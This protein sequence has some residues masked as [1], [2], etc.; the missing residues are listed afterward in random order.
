MKKMRLA[1]DLSSILKTCINVGVDVEGEDVVTPEGKTV[2]VNSA[3]YGYENSVNSILSALKEFD[4]TPIDLVLM[5]E[6]IS[7]KYPRLAIFGEYKL[8]REDVPQKHEQFNLMKA[9]VL[10]LFKSLGAIVIRQNYAEADDTAAYLAKNTRTDLIIMTNDNDLAVLNGTNSYGALVGVR[11]NGFVGV[12]KY[13]DFPYEY[14]TVYKA[15]VGDQSDNISGI[16]GFGAKAFEQFLARFGVAGLQILQRCGEKQTLDELYED[17]LQDKFIA[18]IFAGAEEFLRSYK[19]A[20]L[21]PEW[22]DTMNSPLVF[23][24]GL[25]L[26]GVADERVKQWAPARR[27]VT[28]ATWDKFFAWFKSTA[29]CRDWLA[30]DIETSTP[31]ESDEWVEA[32]GSEDKVDTMGS[33]LTGMSLTFG[34]N[35]QYTVYLPVDHADTDNLTTEQIKVLLEWV[36]EQGLRVKIH[37][38]MFEGPVLFNLFGAAWKDNGFHGFLPNWYD[39]KFAASY[40]NENEPL[41]LKKLA[42]MYFGYD[43]VD[44]H[45]TVTTRVTS[46]NKDVESFTETPDGRYVGCIKRVREGVNT[47]PDEDGTPPILV[48]SDFVYDHGWQ[49]KMRQHTAQHVF[50]YACDDTVVTASFANFAE[51]F[52]DLEGTNEVLDL[53]ETKASYLHAQSFVNG[54]RLDVAKLNELREADKTTAIA[55][56]QALGAYLTTLGWEGTVCPVYTPQIT[57]A[58]VKEAFLIATGKVLD[59][60]VR[61]PAKLVE[62]SAGYS[63]LFSGLLQECY[64]GKPEG[65]NELV[66]NNFKGKPMFN[67]GSPKQMQDLL[68]NTMGSPIVMRNKP[69]DVMKAKGIREGTPSTDALAIAYAMRDAKSDEVKEALRQVQLLKMT[70]IREGLYYKPYPSFVHWRTGKIHPSHNQ[71]ATNTR[72]ASSSSPNVQQMPKHQKV[73]GQPSRFREVM[74]P[75]KSKAVIVSMDFMAQELR[76]IADYS[77]DPNMLSCFVGDSLKDMHALTG[78]G[79]A[80][81]KGYEWSYDTFVEYIND[82]ES[83]YHKLAKQFRAKGKTTNFATEYGA[84]APKLSATMMIPESEAQAYID[85]R[86]DAFSGAKDW[87]LSVVA[88][89]VREGYVTTKMGAVR[90]L[91][92]AVMSPNRATSSKAE[93]QGVNTKIQGSCAEMTKLAEGRMWDAALEQRFDAQIIGPIH[94]EVVASCAIEDLY[95]FIPAMHAC[96]VEAYADMKV[97]IKSSISFGRSFGEQIEIG[98]E[99]TEEAINKGLKELYEFSNSNSSVN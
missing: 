82:T 50:D 45:T 19:L 99:P 5:E 53:V 23:E 40:V 17:S 31:I 32:Q 18:K 47:A 71:C 88:E 87:K 43:Q 21:Y 75:H 73:E 56:E 69:T 41:G 29:P 20:K 95:G 39:T 86:E 52:M 26:G 97:P 91:K 48:D 15:L 57:A 51:F 81:K 12:N 72:R 4:L 2:H 8:K 10:S 78:Q 44:Y 16:K 63:P 98:E 14:I 38:T 35:M 83:E 42:K 74:L 59:T 49:L 27:L 13:G 79:I 9:Q 92:V 96:M 55:A 7:S 25:I 68:Y 80:A 76:V 61:T 66:R 33:L 37:N 3:A 84:Q 1:V 54:F 46:D 30:L 22:V 94:D 70:T 77:Q 90:H 34:S 65:L 85:A 64:D 60:A 36:A 11:V 28:A 89:V 6:G 93:R 58:A 67:A 62:F 24:P